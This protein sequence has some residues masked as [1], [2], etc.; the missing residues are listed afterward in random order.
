[1]TDEVKDEGKYTE[2]VFEC[3]ICRRIYKDPGMCSQ[4]NV[5]LKPKGG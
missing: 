1:M 5:L 4:C 3:Q 2:L